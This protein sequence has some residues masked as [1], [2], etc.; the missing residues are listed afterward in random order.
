MPLRPC[1]LIV[2]FFNLLEHEDVLLKILLI[3]FN[4]RTELHTFIAKCL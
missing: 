2:F 1:A 4:V 3:H